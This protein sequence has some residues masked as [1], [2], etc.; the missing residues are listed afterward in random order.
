MPAQLCTATACPMGGGT[1]TQHHIHQY[2][3]SSNNGDICHCQLHTHMVYQICPKDLQ[4][5]LTPTLPASFLAHSRLLHSQQPAMQQQGTNNTTGGLQTGGKSTKLLQGTNRYSLLGLCSLTIQDDVPKIIRIFDSNKDTTAKFQALK[6]L[7]LM[8]QN[9][10][11]FVNFTL[12]KETFKDLKQHQFHFD[13]D[14]KNMT[15]GFSPFCLQKMDKGSKIA[16][17]QLEEHME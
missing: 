8:A 17:C 7:L 13:H 15:H 12:Q 10:N 5:K 11:A 1:P 9:N 4:H 3:T 2:S 6:D 16:L 14:E